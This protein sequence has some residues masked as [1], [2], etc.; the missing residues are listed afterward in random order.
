[1]AWTPFDSFLARPLECYLNSASAPATNSFYLILT[2]GGT[3][4]D[5]SSLS[6]VLAQE[7]SGNGYARANY[8]PA[9][10]SYDSGQSRYEMPIVTVNFTATT[11]AIQFDKAVL[12]GGAAATG[13]TGELIC[14]EAQTS[15]VTIPAGS[16]YSFQIAFNL[17]GAGVDVS[18][19]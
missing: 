17:G 11:A 6:T 8:D 1:M 4:T 2:L 18:A 15:T 14:Y 13:S 10:G 5:A 7:V 3:I 19:A 9:T 12:I 16:T